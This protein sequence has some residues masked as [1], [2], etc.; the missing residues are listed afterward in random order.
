[1]RVTERKDQKE[2][3]GR[4]GCS[5]WV[6]LTGLLGVGV[7]PKLLNLCMGVHSKLVTGPK[8]K[9]AR[10]FVH[11]VMKRLKPAWLIFAA[12]VA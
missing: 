7:L 1:M 9:K 4:K 6:G 12:S 2:E 11:S 10:A 5:S 8:V 3:G